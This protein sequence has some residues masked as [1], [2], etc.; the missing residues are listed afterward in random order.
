M[1]WIMLDSTRLSYCRLGPGYR[2]DCRA[3]IGLNVTSFHQILI[4]KG[5]VTQGAREPSLGR[6]RQPRLQSRAAKGASCVL[7]AVG[8]QVNRVVTLGRVVKRSPLVGSLVGLDEGCGR[9]VGAVLVEVSGP[10][11]PLRLLARCLQRE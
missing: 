11:N 7:Q 2:L 4:D 9:R 8:E 5:V 1:T 6:L 10:D 3:G